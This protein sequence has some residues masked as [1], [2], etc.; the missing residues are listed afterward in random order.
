MSHLPLAFAVPAFGARLT[1]IGTGLAERPSPIRY[2]SAVRDEGVCSLDIVWAVVPGV[3]NGEMVYANAAA[4][5]IDTAAAWKKARIAQS[6]IQ[7]TVCQSFASIGRELMKGELCIVSV[8][9]KNRAAGYKSFGGVRERYFNIP[10]YRLLGDREDYV[11][12]IHTTSPPV[13]S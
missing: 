2:G 4:D 7:G 8:D 6:M 9:G 3:V 1:A 11:P 12:T 13:F 10:M 5:D